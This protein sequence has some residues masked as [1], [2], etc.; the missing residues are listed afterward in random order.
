MIKTP[1]ST[2]AFIVQSHIIIIIIIIDNI[3]LVVEQSMKRSVF[4]WDQAKS[5]SRFIVLF[6]YEKSEG[7][8]VEM[9]WSGGGVIKERCRFSLVGGTGSE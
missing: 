1:Y 8:G 4:P 2:V 7:G 6:F 3:F 9:S 5:K